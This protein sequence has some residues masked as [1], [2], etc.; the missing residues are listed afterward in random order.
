MH[1]KKL[2][3]VD[4]LNIPI[5]IL[6]YNFSKQITKTSICNKINTFVTTILQFL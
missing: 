2:N 3:K 5:A 4:K 1:I 6:Y